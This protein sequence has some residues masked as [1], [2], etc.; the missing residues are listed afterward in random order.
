VGAWRLFDF[1][2]QAQRPS[3]EAREERGRRRAADGNDEVVD[4]GVGEPVAVEV[5]LVEDADGSVSSGGDGLIDGVT[6]EEALQRGLSRVGKY[7][8]ATPRDIRESLAKFGDASFALPD[9]RGVFNKAAL[10][11]G[12]TK[13][14][15]GWFL[16]HCAQNAKCIAPGC[17]G[18]PPCSHFPAEVEMPET[19]LMQIPVVFDEDNRE[20]VSVSIL[21]GAAIILSWLADPVISASVIS[22]PLE[23]SP[24]H[25]GNASFCS[26]MYFHYLVPVV[27]ANAVPLCIG[28]YSDETTVVSVG[29]RSFHIASL[30]LLN[31]S[32]T[33]FGNDSSGNVSAQ[34]KGIVGGCELG[35]LEAP[36]TVGISRSVGSCGADKRCSNR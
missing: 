24:K 27:P 33:T 14:V 29:T 31:S 9:Q 30:T 4:E 11:L 7:R 13:K 21:P 12:I 26:G 20:V 5:R 8:V 36:E 6:D 22:E 23:R 2:G 28:C 3:G 25:S 32:L 17:A 18:G 16:Q 19:L 15:R 1:V 10:E 34:V 35:A